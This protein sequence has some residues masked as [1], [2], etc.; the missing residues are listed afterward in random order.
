ME[1]DLR[2]YVRIIMK[3]LWLILIFVLVVSITTGVISYMFIEPT[4][5][6]STK[7]IV[8]KS[9]TTNAMSPLDIS[10]INTNLSL[11]N[12]YKEIIKTNAIIDKVLVKYPQF[13]LTPE[14]L[15]NKVSVTSTNNTQVM[16]ISV[17]DPTYGKSVEMVNAISTVFK[18]E[19]PSIM[20]VDN[21]SILNKAVMV[22]NPQPIK[23]NKKLNVAIS[24]IV[25]LMIALGIVFLFEYLDDTIKTE[26]DV[27]TILGLPTLAA[28]SKMKD[29][30]LQAG[31]SKSSKKQVGETAHVTI[32]Q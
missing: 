7:L 32:N 12:T 4:Y 27:H 8:N 17:Q 26:A 1:L 10:E 16:T 31:E 22:D 21:V 28:I 25:S 18:E 11:I 6:A 13:N 29:E 2:D 19:I 5:E 9:D 24:F 14:E 20:K 23:P 30:D 3:R 15:I